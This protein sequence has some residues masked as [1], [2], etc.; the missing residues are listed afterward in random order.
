LT[1]LGKNADNLGSKIK[2]SLTPSG[3]GSSPVV[4]R[5]VVSSSSTGSTGR[6]TSNSEYLGGP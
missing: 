5:P 6:A 4:D 1:D 2:S 3:T